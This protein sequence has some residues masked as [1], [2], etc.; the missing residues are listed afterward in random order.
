MDP[1]VKGV[2]VGLII[3]ISSILLGIFVGWLLYG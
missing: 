1:V 2:I 3:I